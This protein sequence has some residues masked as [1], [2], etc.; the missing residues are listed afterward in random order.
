MRDALRAALEREAEKTKP[1]LQAAPEKEYDW[2]PHAK[3]MSL[4][5]LCTHIAKTPGG[6]ISMLTKTVLDVE[7]IEPINEAASSTKELL[8][9]FDESVSSAISTLSTW[10]A[11]DLKAGWQLKQKGQVIMDMPLSQAV[12]VFTLNHF[13][14]HRGQLSVYLRLLDAPVP[15]VYGPTAD[16]NPFG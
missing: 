4:G 5:I 6:T 11:H 8:Q 16:D 14:H 9:L 10:S 3:S 12:R 7:N 1:L 13:Y 15:A 2:K